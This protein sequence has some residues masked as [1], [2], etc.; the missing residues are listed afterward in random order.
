MQTSL[1]TRLYNLSQNA[2]FDNCSRLSQKVNNH[3]MKYFSYA[4]AQNKGDSKGI[5]AA[6]VASFPMRLETIVTVRL[7]GVG[8][9]LTQPPTG[10]KTGPTEK[11]YMGKSAVS[12]E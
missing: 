11:I 6:L 9:K 7:L 1:T 8:S 5:Q 12:F 4:I 10:I 3:L 2:K